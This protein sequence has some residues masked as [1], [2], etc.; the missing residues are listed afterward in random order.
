VY[1]SWFMAKQLFL[2]LFI[3]CSIRSMTS[4]VFELQPALKGKSREKSEQSLSTEHSRISRLTSLA[5]DTKDS[6]EP[7]HRLQ[8]TPSDCR[9]EKNDS[10]FQE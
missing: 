9:K 3:S 2:T 7:S 10:T 5:P 6:T 8:E 4:K 1:S